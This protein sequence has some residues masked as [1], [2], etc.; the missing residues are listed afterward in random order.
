M[1]PNVT[2]N[3]AKQNKNSKLFLLS[4]I[5]KKNLTLTKNI[6]KDSNSKTYNRETQIRLIE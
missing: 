5:K 6:L 1:D 4:Q 2:A 3:N